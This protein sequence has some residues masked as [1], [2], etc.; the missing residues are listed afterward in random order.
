MAHIH[1]LNDFISTVFIVFQGKVLL[2]QHEKYN[3]WTG[4]GGHVE[5]DEDP[6]QAAIREVKEEV[7]LDIE[8]ISDDIYSFPAYN[9]KYKDLVAP[10]A[11]NIH[12]IKDG[13]HH[14]IDL[15]FAAIAHTDQVILESPN[16]VVK[17]MTKDEIEAADFLDDRRKKYSLKALEIASKS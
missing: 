12:Q 2:R 14:H 5:L 13:P 11:M 8:L 1:E 7:G 4:A 15:I 6:N 3:I 9:H 10:F 17:W 16:D